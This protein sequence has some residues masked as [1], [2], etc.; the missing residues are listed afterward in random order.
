[1]NL[2]QKEKRRTGMKGTRGG[3]KKRL[4]IYRGKCARKAVFE[5]RVGLSLS[6][7]RI[8]QQTGSGC[9]GK[10]PPW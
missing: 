5:M 9:G 1:P 6:E 10:E 8:R 7:F 2:K 3:G 4:L